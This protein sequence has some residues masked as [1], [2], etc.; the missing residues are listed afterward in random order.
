MAG[1]E[2][3]G[4]LRNKNIEKCRVLG[5]RLSYSQVAGAE[6]QDSSCAQEA[7]RHSKRALSALRGG[8]RQAIRRGGGPAVCWWRAG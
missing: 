4:G 5:K 8:L 3:G 1:L 6:D 7:Q 2:K